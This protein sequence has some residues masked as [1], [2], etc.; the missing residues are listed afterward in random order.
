MQDSALLR[1]ALRVVSSGSLGRRKKAQLSQK[2]SALQGLPA[3]YISHGA[4]CG[5]RGT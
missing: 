1:L 3:N 4:H 2:T 5:T